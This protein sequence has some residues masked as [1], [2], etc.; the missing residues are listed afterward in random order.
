MLQV[1]VSDPFE[2]V[3]SVPGLAAPSYRKFLQYLFLKDML[4]RDALLKVVFETVGR[5]LQPTQ[6][7]PPALLNRF[8]KE[9]T[10]ALKKLPEGGRF[11][12][13]DRNFPEDAIQVLQEFTENLDGKNIRYDA[14][15]RREPAKSNKPKTAPKLKDALKEEPECT[16]LSILNASESGP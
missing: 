5:E 14:L 12:I 15:L 1:D 3:L 8:Q 11:T 9:M 16:R 7:L 4:K 10:A 13:S 6:S 2:L